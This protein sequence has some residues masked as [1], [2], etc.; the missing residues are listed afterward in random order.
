LKSLSAKIDFVR[1]CSL[2]IG[3]LTIITLSSFPFA[4]A[5]DQ[6]TIL[7]RDL[8]IDLGDGLTTDAQLTY[9]SVGEGPFPGLLLLHGSGNTDMDQ[10]IPPEL[11]DTEE[12]SRFLLQI[13]EYL[14]ERGFAVLRYN[15]RGIGLNGTILD[16]GV[17]VNM[18]FQDL[19]QDAEKALEVLIQQPEVDKDDI[20]ILGHSEGTFI[21]PRI[22]LR[23]PNVKK[24][25]LMSAAAH[26]LYDIL[27]F[28]IVEQ[29]INQFREIDSNNDGLLSVQEVY[30]LP[31]VMKDSLIENSTGEW[32][33]YPGID[34]NGDG[35]ISLIE[36]R[37]PPWNRTFE[38]LTT[39]EYPG[40]K[41]MQSHFPLE[42]NLDIIE[43]VT[44]SIL[45]LQAEGDT[46]TPVTEAFLL[47]QKLT[48]VGNPDHTLI[49]YPGLGHSFY[50]RDG[51]LQWLGPIQN[52]V[53]SD[54][55]NWLNDP[56]RDM[57]HLETQLETANAM[58]AKLQGQLEDE[59]AAVSILESQMEGLQSQLDDEQTKINKLDD[60]IS[61]L[62]G[63]NE[64]L[65]NALSFSRNLNYI[66]I[67]IAVIAAVMTVLAY[68][69]RST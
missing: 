12:G 48:E 53:L 5:L 51:L 6:E 35:Y 23:N 54:L 2:A 1:V 43:N 40:S 55:G 49:T 38:Y 39:A 31:S 26:N 13:A 16:E 27:Y 24:I 11:S 30:V 17:V 4:L 44:A 64:E 45:I 67:G 47:E 22:A 18:T 21:A 56:D 57:H 61:G 32:R 59:Q 50:P 41:W 63:E 69:R 3:F 19:Q 25:V 36:E 34:P 7:H 15:K 29:G 14:S 66:A 58:I 9:P 46:Q 42:R 65:Q 28:Q 60:T 10:Y 33:W 52:Y 68:Q 62:E 8:V 37:I 20:T